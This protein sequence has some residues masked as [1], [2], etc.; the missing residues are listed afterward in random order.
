MAGAATFCWVSVDS[1]G[2]IFPYSSES[3]L[4]LEAAYNLWLR[5]SGAS[6]ASVLVDG[7]DGVLLVQVLFDRGGHMQV[8]ANGGRRDVQRLEGEE[9]GGLAITCQRVVWASLDPVEGHIVPYAAAVARKCEDAY[10]GG[11][12]DVP[13]DLNTP[14]G[15]LFARVYFK[16]DG[17]KQETRHGLRSVFRRLLDDGTELHVWRRQL[18]DDQGI[19]SRRFRL[20]DQDAEGAE[21]VT[22]SVHEANSVLL[23]YV[24]GFPSLATQGDDAVEQLGIAPEKL[25]ACRD[26]LTS[27]GVR[28]AA[29]ALYESVNAAENL[30]APIFV[31]MNAIISAW[32][33]SGGVSQ[34]GILGTPCAQGELPEAS[35]GRFGLDMRALLMAH[36]AAAIQSVLDP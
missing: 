21:C 33:L 12:P 27:E 34:S 9:A 22:I 17:F 25:R 35:H 19:D 31:H 32:E 18:G 6:E 2:T 20:C 24:A 13:I 29:R 4:R 11:K 8:T 14:S 5:N 15:S 26:R 7:D 23:G 30:G 1:S 36:A 16:E 28:I 3:C 10:A